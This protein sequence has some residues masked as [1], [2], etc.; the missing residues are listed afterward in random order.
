MRGSCNV[1]ISVRVLLDGPF[2][3][4]WRKKYVESDG[5]PSVTLP[6]EYFSVDPLRLCLLRYRLLQLLLVNPHLYYPFALG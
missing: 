4:A 6:L 2:L 3:G 5:M 1:P